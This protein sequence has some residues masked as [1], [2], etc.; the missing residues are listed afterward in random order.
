MGVPFKTILHMSL[1][2]HLIGPKV[3]IYS[4][5]LV[6]RGIATERSR[7]NE[8][9]WEETCDFGQKVGSAVAL[10]NGRFNALV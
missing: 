1:L 10:V 3:W 7:S 8:K 2:I 5:T 4:C 6:A 9:L